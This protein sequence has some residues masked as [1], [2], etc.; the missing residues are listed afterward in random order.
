MPA[1]VEEHD[2]RGLTVTNNL[3][4]LFPAKADEIPPEGHIM[5]KVYDT[6]RALWEAAQKSATVYNAAANRSIEE[7]AMRG[8]PEPDSES[9]VRKEAY[10]EMAENMHDVLEVLALDPEI[11]PLDLCTGRRLES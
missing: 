3:K 10:W 7:Y 4:S 5:R 8:I 6:D 2:A 9:A 11:D 1:T